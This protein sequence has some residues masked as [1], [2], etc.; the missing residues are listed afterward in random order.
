[1]YDYAYLI[2]DKNNTQVYAVVGAISSL[3]CIAA[4]V[5]GLVLIRRRKSRARNSNLEIKL[6][7]FNKPQPGEMSQSDI[8]DNIRNK[9]KDLPI[10]AEIKLL[11]CNSASEEGLDLSKPQPKDILRS[12]IGDEV[13]KKLKYIPGRE[14]EVKLLPCNEDSNVLLD[15]SKTQAEKILCSDITDR[16]T[17][18]HDSDVN[19]MTEHTM[20]QIQAI[21]KTLSERQANEVHRVLISIIKQRST[22]T[23]VRNFPV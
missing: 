20:E 2:S 3:I 9:P 18:C 19:D 5:F 12:D 23:C 15:L 8:G 17:E 6:D 16:D 13:G 21:N 11:P 10:D 22:N 4:L 7:H 1:M 14:E